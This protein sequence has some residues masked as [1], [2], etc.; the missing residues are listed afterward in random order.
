VGKL[1]L[2]SGA[3]VVPV[4]IHGSASVR[5][6]KKL[7]FPKVTVQYGAPVSFDRVESPT[8]EQQQEAAEKVFE[9]VRAMYDA[10]EAK[11]RRGVLRDLRHGD[12][13]GP[14]HLSVAAAPGPAERQR[15]ESHS[16]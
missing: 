11:G 14:L 7:R 2:E 12:E 1:A 4:A 13:P 3:P 15:T 16:S 8:P 10:L 9:R 6:W 5:R